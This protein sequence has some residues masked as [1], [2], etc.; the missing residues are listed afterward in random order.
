MAA[1]LILVAGMA[2]TASPA[3]AHAC[4]TAASIPVGK[5]STVNV[6][7]T[8]EATPPQLIAIAIPPDVDL[9]EPFPSNDWTGEKRPIRIPGGQIVTS[10][11][12]EGGKA[13]PYSCAY[14]PVSITPHTKGVY[15][16]TAY[17]KLP[18]GSSVV[19]PSQNDLYRQPNG[20]LISPSQGGPPNPLFEQVVYAGVTAGNAVASGSDKGGFGWLVATLVAVGILAFT[21]LLWLLLRHRSRRREE[22][23]QRVRDHLRARDTAHSVE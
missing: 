8:I 22:R 20:E 7:V 6:G 17:Q 9:N 18:D 13:T 23:V 1:A 11:I 4:T 15:V 3:S 12:Y 16:L 21:G 5:S 10:A 14:F 19:L 2:G